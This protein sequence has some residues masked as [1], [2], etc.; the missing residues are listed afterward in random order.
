MKLRSDSFAARLTA[1][2]R[3][4]LFIA[5]AGG[6]GLPE[7]ASKVAEWTKAE[8]GGRRPSTQAISAWYQGAKVERRFAAAKES[9]LIA[10]ANCPA[11]YDLQ[12]RTAL[13]HAK[14]LATL[15]E[16]TPKDIAVLQKN[17]LIERKLDLDQ[18]KFELDR[19]RLHLDQEKFLKLVMGQLAELQEIMREPG[20]DDDARLERVRQRVFG[21][22]ENVPSL[23]DVDQRKGAK[24]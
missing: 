14:F 23:A 16:L 1:S 8:W 3:D 22:P 6:L 21:M 18:Q 9:A 13:G 19:E 20:L 12:A 5:L 7:A 15:E 17:E 4:D 2:Q 11:D 24:S 10:Q